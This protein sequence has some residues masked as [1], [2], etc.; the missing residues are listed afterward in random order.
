MRHPLSTLIFLAV[1]L[2][3]LGGLHYY[4]WRRIVRDPF[5]EGRGRRLATWTFAL[6]AGVLGT[7]IL[8]GRLLLQ[9]LPRWARYV[10]NGWLGL[11]ALAVSILFLVD[12]ARALVR[13]VRPGPTEPERR[14]LFARL[15]AAGTGAASLGLG[16][17]GVR[18]ALRRVRVKRLS[19]ALDRLPAAADGY[20]LVQLTDMHVGATLDGAFVEQIVAEVEALRPDLIA[21]TGDLVD[22][23]IALLDP[24]LQPLRRLRPR[25]G[26]YFVTGNHEYYAG[27]RAWLAHLPSLGLRPLQNERVRFPGFEL[28]GVPDWSARHYDDE[29]KPDV[30]R[31]VAGR[32]ASLPLILL[33]HQPAHAEEA[34]AN[35]VDLQLAGHTHGGQMFPVTVLVHLYTRFVAGLYRR[36]PFQIYVS[37]GTGF[38]GPPMRLG[39]E[40]E[41][42]EITL[43]RA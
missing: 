38:W 37:E 41:V 36:G 12:V 13:T 18:T 22:G 6:V 24:W 20:R 31:A 8:F 23:P 16:A 33:A 35:G 29:V 25:D 30:A 17:W 43:R 40:A 15:V 34:Q 27:A 26:V 11:F 2:S 21:V 32:D 42:T 14:R 19:I 3:V 1:F 39:T 9:W 10:A 4:L 28:A 7:G 5:A